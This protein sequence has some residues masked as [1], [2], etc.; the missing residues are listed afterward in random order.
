METF[1][2]LGYFPRNNF[3]DI[4]AFFGNE[5]SNDKSLDGLNLMFLIL[6]LSNHE[7]ERDFINIFMDDFA[8]INKIKDKKNIKNKSNMKLILNYLQANYTADVKIN[9]FV[10]ENEEFITT[11]NSSTFKHN[12]NVCIFSFKFNHTFFI[13]A[14]ILLFKSI[15]FKSMQRLC[16]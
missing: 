15:E 13:F 10:I 6:L 2:Q 9:N 12:L 3:H 14:D 1:F 8:K 5:V 11:A 7:K 16:L 4:L